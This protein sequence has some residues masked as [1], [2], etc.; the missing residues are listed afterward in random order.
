MKKALIDLTGK[1]FDYLTVIKR[2]AKKENTPSTYW[3]CICSCGNNLSVES[4]RL[5]SGR[6]GSCGCKKGSRVSKK[7]TQHGHCAN[8]AMSR[9]YASWR[10]AIGRCHNENAFGFTHY[11]AIGI[12]VC[13]RWRNSF[14]D[15]LSDMGERPIGTTLDRWPDKSG[16]YFPGNCRWATPSEQQNNLKN[17]RLVSICGETITIREACEKYQF[18]YSVTRNA[19]YCKRI[20]V[21]KSGLVMELI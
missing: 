16:G 7:I 21:N 6:T 5:R 2:G 4:S 18:D 20:S 17:N 15:F 3:D 11:G 14:D 8:D 1:T 10:S 12:Q 13:D 9:T 19:L